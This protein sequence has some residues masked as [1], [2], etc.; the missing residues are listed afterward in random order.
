[1]KSPAPVPFRGRSFTE[2]KAAVRDALDDTATMQQVTSHDD[3]GDAVVALFTML[4]VPAVKVAGTVLDAGYADRQ[5]V[6]AAALPDGI[7]GQF[8]LNEQWL[9][10]Y[11]FGSRVS[12]VGTVARTIASGGARFPVVLA[13]APQDRPSDAA[14]RAAVIGAWWGARRA[15]GHSEESARLLL[16]L[17]AHP[18]VLAMV[19]ELDP[20]LPY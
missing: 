5:T 10:S 19:R 20:T 1:M 8:T 9:T 6:V 12:Q 13:D 16:A 18:A 2:V 3:L 14:F 17:A 7:V 4:D 11:A 15:E